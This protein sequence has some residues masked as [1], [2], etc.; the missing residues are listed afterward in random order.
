MFFFKHT[1]LT[2]LLGLLLIGVQASVCLGAVQDVGTTALDFSKLNT[3]V[4]ADSMGNAMTA[5]TELAAM[6]LNPASLA[7]LKTAEINVQQLGYIQD[8]SYQ[9]LHSAFPTA[10]GTFGIEA[11]IVDLGR[12]T[13]TLEG[14]GASLGTFQNRGYQMKIAYGQKSGDWSY[15]GGVQYISQTLDTKTSAGMGLDLGVLYTVNPQLSFG[16]AANNI[17]LVRP[18]YV[19]DTAIIPFS[20]R[21]GVQS[22][23]SLWDRPLTLFSD[24][25]SPQDD[26][27]YCGA[28]MDIN[29][30]GPL[31]FRLGYSNYG[32]ADTVVM[33]LGFQ[34]ESVS[35]DFAYKPT[36]D[37]G[38]SYRLGFG[39]K[40]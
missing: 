27:V 5:G 12:Q 8:I 26:G 29:L 31:S 16:A 22:K 9:L 34:F 38:Q 24:I 33:G 19:T 3:S 39:M 1:L 21:V 4:K 7:S 37:L 10:M 13:R 28:G 32:K 14:S 11:G 30:S 18:T 15:G 17:S 36:K 6:T 25:V 23:L 35:I 20:V 2:S 40:L